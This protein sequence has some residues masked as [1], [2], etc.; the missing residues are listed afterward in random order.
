VRDLCAVDPL[1]P[2]TAATSSRPPPL[3]ER[4]QGWLRYLHRKATTPDDWDR[5]GQPHPHW[6][7]HS[8]P[9]MLCWHRFDLIDSTYAIALMADRTPAWREVYA[10]ILDELIFRH[11]GWW[12]ARD[13]LTQIGH[14]PDRASYPDLYRVL[15]PEHLWGDYDV[16]G[17]T[18]NGIEPW[19]LQMDPIGADGNLFFKGF[20]LV[21]LGLHLRTTGDDRW[22]DPFD[23][24]RDGENT[25]TWFHSA[26]AEHLHSQWLTKPDGCHCENTK[27]WP[28][29]LAGAGLGLQLHD[30][31]R[32]TSHHEVFDGWWDGVCRDRYL[33]LDGP[34]LPQMVTLY[35]DPILDVAHEVPVFAGMVPAI[36]LAPQVPDGARRLFEAGMTQLGLWEPGG[37]VSLPGPRAS[38]TALWLAREW[39]LSSIEAALSEQIDAQYQPT[40]DTATGEF[41]WGFELDEEYPRGQYNGTMAAAQVATRDS[42]WRL[43]NELPGSRFTEP[44]VEGVD[45]P[46]VSLD[47]AWWDRSRSELSIGTTPMSPAVV[48]RPTS[49]RVVNLDSPERWTVSVTSPEPVP[50]DVA[51]CDGGIEIR[52]TVGR[53]QF[54]VSPR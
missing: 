26:I 46:T 18:A 31:L 3:D 10:R 1:D 47:E 50:V 24:V 49:F 41:T 12:A 40:F 11:T 9:P 51:P 7:D 8:D 25:F 15:I 39:G 4:A 13:W 2:V 22:N 35:Y 43:A 19:G 32:G 16:P 6:D 45:F 36:Y 30:L 17:W 54:V 5:A 28:Y 23:I 42:W 37:S 52:T 44:T 34:E 21:M 14:D 38:A 20:F 53:H 33:H 29:C 27:V 48:G